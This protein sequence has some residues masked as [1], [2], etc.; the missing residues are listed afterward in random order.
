MIS[1]GAFLLLTG[2]SFVQK[3][4]ME[5]FTFAKAQFFNFTHI[6]LN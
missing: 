4:S 1:I 5:Y 6:F 2:I 3:R